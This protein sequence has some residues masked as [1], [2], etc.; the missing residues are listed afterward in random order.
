MKNDFHLKQQYGFLFAKMLLDFG[1]GV[2][3]ESVGECVLWVWLLALLESCEQD[4]TSASDN[5]YQR[6]EYTPYGELWIEKTSSEASAKYLPYKFTG[7]ERDEETGLYYFGARYLDAKYSR[8][9]STDPALGEYVPL[10]PLDDKSRRHN[11]NLPGMGGVYNYINLQVYHYAGNNPIKYTD[12][13]GNFLVM[14]G[15]QGTAGAGTGA[16]GQIGV[17]ACWDK[18][19]N[20][21]IGTYAVIGGGFY[22]GYT[23]S[24]GGEVTLGFWADEF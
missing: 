13:D 2:F 6:L 15:I 11:E 1:D 24:V 5:E 4:E 16:T 22:T 20:C 18:K 7:K 19:G 21:T 23:P 12:P 10:S 17:Y 3:R 14:V 9:L 8:W